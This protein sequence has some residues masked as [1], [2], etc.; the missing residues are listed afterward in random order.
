MT[1]A[2]RLIR[3]FGA[4][5]PLALG[6]GVGQA[7][8]IRLPEGAETVLSER[9][10]A[11]AH[12]IA[13][14]P[15]RDGR[16][17]ML[18]ITGPLERDIWRLPVTP[19]VSVNGL[20]ASV[21]MQ[22]RDAGYEIVL[23]CR[24]RACGGF[25]FRHSLDMGRS[26]EM[27]VDIGNYRY[28]SALRAG[29]QEAVAVT[30]SRGGEMLYV[31]A[32]QVGATSGERPLPA[33]RAPDAP[34]L[35]VSSVAEGLIGELLDT[36][37]APLDD[38]GFASGASDLSEGDY[39]S[40]AVLAEFL[41]ADPNRRVVLVGHTDSRGGLEGNIDLSEARAAAVRDYLV[42][43]LG[44]ASDQVDAAGIGYLAPRAT[45]ATAEGRQA[46]RRVEVVL[47]TPG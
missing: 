35:P 13:T 22:L 26:P 15:W 37:A 18:E 41:A 4:L 29:Q 23:S 11:G 44:V 42:D 8:D 14:G 19:E 3:I 28:V 39:A 38:L 9:T 47:V 24:E 10:E 45:N 6:P 31:H 20:A 25:D 40:L 7:L 32:V 21:E 5:L 12:E 2:R 34:D 17:P 43:L 27:Y 33:G 46:N 30:V 36:G 1:S 16:L